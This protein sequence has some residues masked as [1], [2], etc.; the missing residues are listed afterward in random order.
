MRIRWRIEEAVDRWSNRTPTEDDVRWLD[1]MVQNDL[2][3]N[4]DQC[5]SETPATGRR[6]SR[7][8]V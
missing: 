6:I 4:S 5:L 2:M 3:P 8:R 7:N 1:W